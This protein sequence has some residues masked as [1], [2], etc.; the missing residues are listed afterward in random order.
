LCIRATVR[1]CFCKYALLGSDQASKISSMLTFLHNFWFIQ[2]LGAVALVFV[3]FSWNAKGRKGIFTLQSI[4]LVFFTFHYVLLGAYTGALMCVVVLLRNFVFVK[5]GVKKW[6]SHVVWLYLFSVLSIAVLALSWNGWISILPVVAVTIGMYGMF[7]ENTKE[8]RFYNLINSL[9]WV[10]YTIS[11]H[12]YSGLLS[13]LVGI[14]GVLVGM[15]RHDRKNT[16][17]VQNSINS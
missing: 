8:M 14:S 17:A 3:F 12:S 2:F 15:Y 5:K 16:K 1:S 13:Q 11:V 10:P 9:I 7:K 4:N 6:A